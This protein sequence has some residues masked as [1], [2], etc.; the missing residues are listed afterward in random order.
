MKELPV[1]ILLEKNKTATASAWLVLLEILLNDDT[2][3]ILRFVRNSEDITFGGDIYT[4][5]PFQLEATQQTSKGEIKGVTLKVGNITNLL[6]PYLEELNGAIGSTV[7]ITVVNSEH[8][9]E[10]Y[11]ELELTYD[12]L[13]TS[14]DS[15]WVSFTL[16]APNP[17]RQRFPLFKY[18]ALHCNFQYRDVEDQIGPRCNYTPEN[19]ISISQ[20]ASA[21]VGVT[22]HPFVIGDVLKFADVLGMTEINGL[23]GTITAINANDFTI[24]INT[25][26]FTAYSSAGLVGYA[27]CKKTLADCR[28]RDNSTRFG[29]TPGMRSGSVRIA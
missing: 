5:F 3:T 28:I 6:E 17:L 29:G 12:V 15:S 25:S 9:A 11:T 18:S 10:D 22:G 19:I 16:G 23:S 27:V 4:A 8:L 14:S 1:N 13:A 2:S 21:I 24:D 26:A 7:N 20:A